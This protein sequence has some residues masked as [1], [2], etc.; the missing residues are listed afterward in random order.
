ML[1]KHS[2]FLIVN[3]LSL[4]QGTGLLEFVFPSLPSQVS[5]LKKMDV[6]EVTH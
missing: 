6:G 1:V 4:V 2:Q 3:F 5:A